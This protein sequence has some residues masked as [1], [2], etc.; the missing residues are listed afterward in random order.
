MRPRSEQDEPPSRHSR[1][2]PTDSSVANPIVTASHGASGALNAEKSD[3]NDTIRKADDG[4]VVDVPDDVEMEWHRGEWHETEYL[5]MIDP[6]R[7]IPHSRSEAES[8]VYDRPMPVLVAFNNDV[9]STGRTSVDMCASR[10]P[11]LPLS[12]SSESSFGHIGMS[13]ESRAMSVESRAM[14]VE[15]RNV[16][17]DSRGVSISE[18]HGTFGR[19]GSRIRWSRG[20]SI[21]DEDN[22][23]SFT[24]SA[25]GDDLEEDACSPEHSPKIPRARMRRDTPARTRR[26]RRCDCEAT[27]FLSPDVS[28][29]RAMIRT[30][31]PSASSINIFTPNYSVASRCRPGSN[32]SVD[33]SASPMSQK[34]LPSLPPSP[35]T[36]IRPVSARLKPCVS[37]TS[38]GS[39]GTLAPLYPVD[40]PPPSPVHQTIKVPHPPPASA[41]RL[42]LAAQIQHDHLRTGKHAFR[43]SKPP[44][45]PLSDP[46]FPN[47][48]RH[49][50]HTIPKTT[51]MTLM[52]AQ[53]GMREI[54]CTLGYRRIHNPAFFR[55]KER[56]SV[57]DAAAHNEKP[58][59]PELFQ[60]SGCIEFGMSPKSR[61]KWGVHHSVCPNRPGGDLR[62]THWSA[63]DG[64]ACAEPMY[65]QQRGE[66]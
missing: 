53:E 7:R 48:I 1:R 20:V 36:T 57:A 19:P 13:L 4:A 12:D 22:R 46:S 30:S 59:R 54:S 17:L 29:A 24:L 26:T 44:P 64:L 32:I 49:A 14:S 15:S 10:N 16:S 51:T 6:F 21:C 2:S 28:A 50:L 42:P 23:S 35:R 31:P 56:K 65:P 25:Y 11:S 47:P 9:F 39:V 43:R 27:P 52:I 33:H 8:L 61:P 62:S 58:P 60:E 45:T 41:P 3:Q 66:A 34:P 18:S 55:Q 63:D 40:S 38:M 37:N 5:D